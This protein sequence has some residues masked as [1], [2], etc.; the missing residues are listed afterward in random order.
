ML[1]LPVSSAPSFTTP[2]ASRDQAI[3][4]LQQA[5]SIFTELEIPTG[6]GWVLYSLGRA[7]LG[8]GRTEEAFGYLH[9]ALTIRRSSGE[10]RNQAMTLKL[11]GE[12][13]DSIGDADGARDSWTQALTLFRGLGDEA[14]SA[15]LE[16]ILARWK[17]DQTANQ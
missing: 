2:A 1:E 3:A 17:Q 14:Q 10:A 13:S 9:Q 4:P 15:E 7:N 12:V 5:R 11:I 8:L 6:E 16:E